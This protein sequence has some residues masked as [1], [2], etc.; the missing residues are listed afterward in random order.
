MATL[1]SCEM[2]TNLVTFISVTLNI[3]NILIAEQGIEARWSHESCQG[4]ESLYAFFIG[5][6]CISVATLPQSIYCNHRL[7]DLSDNRI[8]GCI[9]YSAL[10]ST[11]GFF[12]AIIG[13]YIILHITI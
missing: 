11:L 9:A 8:S 1:G 2:L 12:W 13:E 5:V 3:Y 7:S 6:I 4:A 10:V